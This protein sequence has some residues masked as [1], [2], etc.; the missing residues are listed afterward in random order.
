MDAGA[1]NLVLPAQ[2]NQSAAVEALAI[3][4]SSSFEV[5]Q[6]SEDGRPTHVRT[7]GSGPE[8]RPISVRAAEREFTRCWVQAAVADE[9]DPYFLLDL[10]VQNSL[11]SSVEAYMEVHDLGYMAP[12]SEEAGAEQIEQIQ[13]KLDIQ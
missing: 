11:L 12:I 6:V 7:R 2:L 3:S 13:L 4:L 1:W 9:S 5:V 10:R 8:A